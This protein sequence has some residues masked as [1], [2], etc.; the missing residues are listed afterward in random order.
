MSGWVSGT[1]ATVA[2]VTS[3][4]VTTACCSSVVPP[5]RPKGETPEERR[6]RKLAIREERKVRCLGE[7]AAVFSLILRLSPCAGETGSKAVV[8]CSTPRWKSLFL[9]AS[10]TVCDVLASL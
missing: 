3:A 2:R 1:R 6:M 9:V 5:V 10:L 4:R 8:T 7:V